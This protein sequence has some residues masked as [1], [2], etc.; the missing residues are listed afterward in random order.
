MLWNFRN[1]RSKVL[2]SSIQGE[3]TTMYQ[4]SGSLFQKRPHYFKEYSKK[5]SK[6]LNNTKSHNLSSKDLRN[7]PGPVS[8]YWNLIDTE[9]ELTTSWKPKCH[10]THLVGNSNTWRLGILTF[11]HLIVDLMVP[12]SPHLWTQRHLSNHEC[13]IRMTIHT[14]LAELLFL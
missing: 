6:Y 4:F 10:H 9:S 8:V 5:Q 1:K 3:I 14:E 11:I 12:Q 7:L 13:I 2:M